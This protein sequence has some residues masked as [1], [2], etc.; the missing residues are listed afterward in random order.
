MSHLNSLVDGLRIG[1]I[2]VTGDR[3]SCLCNAAAERLLGRRPQSLD[4]L[5]KALA[6]SGADSTAVDSFETFV[7]DALEKGYITVAV[8]LPGGDIERRF[9]DV[10]VVKILHEGEAVLLLLDA[11]ELGATLD[12]QTEN[13]ERLAAV[14][15]LAAGVTHELNNILT[16]ILGWTQIALRAPD[17]QEKVESAL[18]IIDE[19]CK[20]AKSIIDDVMGFARPTAPYPEQVHIAEVADE[21]FRVLSFELH[22]GSIKIDKRYREVPPV[23][24]NR[25]KLFQIFLNIVLNAVQ[26]MREGGV[27]AVSTAMS[28]DMTTIEF[29]DNG[30]GMDAETISKIF[31]PGFTTKRPE[32]TGG[33]SGLGLTISRKLLE[34]LGGD[35]TVE[36]QFGSGSSFTV[37]LPTSATD[38][39]ADRTAPER[40]DISGDLRV[41]V[42]DD[43]AHIREM[44]REALEGGA[45]EIAI[46]RS[47]I[48]AIEMNGKDQFDLAIVDY[49]MPGISGQALID[50]LKNVSPEL[51]MLV[52]TGRLDRTDVNSTGADEVLRKPFDLPEL[53]R[54]LENATAKASDENGSKS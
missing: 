52:L 54:A 37:R 4:E 36:S 16:A 19:N 12:L 13:T 25:R 31:E 43:E 6:K 1:A 35:I 46:A 8:D 7:D 20:R 3:E 34:K 29:R 18:S 44:I 42:V 41:L 53:L 48:E 40:S 33:G 11:E 39:P 14:G 10:R 27:L 2:A 50:R 15:Q 21:V 17:H 28:D 51:S 22:N 38:D 47:G 5:M 9:V 32:V 30:H 24:S 45:A 23:V 26:A 49:S